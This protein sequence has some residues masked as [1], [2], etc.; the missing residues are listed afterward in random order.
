MQ[1]PDCMIGVLG[2]TSLVGQR[3]LSLA[4]K[5]GNDFHETLIAFSRNPEAIHFEQTSR[6]K[7]R[8]LLANGVLEKESTIENW[9]SLSPIWVLSDYFEMLE[10]FKVR[11]IIVLSSTSR[12]TKTESIDKSEQ[13]VAQ[14]LTEGEAELKNWAEKN[15]VEWIVLR[16]TLIYG[17]GQDKNIAAVAR[18][19]RRFRFFPLL[20][21]A[22]GLR[23][24]I[25]ADDV[26]TA[27]LQV[28]H[29]KNVV[30]RAYNISG[31][32]TLSYAEMIQKV[33]IAL[34]MK[35]RY[36]HVPIILFRF[37]VTLLR[38]FPRLNNISPGM[39]ERMN[40][41]LIFSHTSASH[42]FE[43][44]P[45]NFDLQHSDIEIQE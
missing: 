38:W 19:I 25:H 44:Q 23:Q 24:P 32:E 35:P 2:A 13:L 28:L 17:F 36:L 11:R 29:Q 39:A 26:A 15:Q 34:G 31:G 6:I 16:P 1:N 7:W 42:D 40:S 27:C 21:N 9:I 12:F 33:F 20:G 3:L 8:S 45:R 37:A 10:Q 43:F 4:T 18:F 5:Q 41:D 22:S 14:R 30:N